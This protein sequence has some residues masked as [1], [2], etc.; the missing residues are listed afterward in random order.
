[1]RVAFAIAVLPLVALT[2]C[3]GP[4]E[5]A[6]ATARTSPGA[7]ATLRDA[8]GIEKGRVQIAPVGSGRLALSLQA[9]GLP[10]GT[11]AFHVHTTGKCEAPGFTTAG[12]HWNPAMKQH[13]RDN[14]MGAHAG[15][16]PNLVVGAD[17]RT[18]ARTEIDG[19]LAQLFDADGA[20]VIIHAAADDYR[21]DPTGNAG[22]RMACG[23]LT[24][25]G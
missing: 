7:T 5:G 3:V 15:D 22:P 9:E 18:S 20:A 2:A 4:G 21:T 8:A 12:G 16:M 13:G 19:D 11:L 25:G 17:G 14:P 23:V 24:R 10:P 6:P 1:M